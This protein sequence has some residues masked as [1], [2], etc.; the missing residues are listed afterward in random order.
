ML[1]SIPFLYTRNKSLEGEIQEIIS[2]NT[3]QKEQNT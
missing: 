1:T 2:F 3:G